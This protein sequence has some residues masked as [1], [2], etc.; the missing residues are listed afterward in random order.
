MEHQQQSATHHIAQR[1]VGLLP[2]PGF[3][4]LPRQLPAA[5]LRMISNQLPDEEDLFPGDVSAPVAMCDHLIRGVPESVSERQVKNRRLTLCAT[6]GPHRCPDC[7]PPA[8]PVP[9]APAAPASV[10]RL[11]AT[12]ESVPWKAAW[13]PT[14]SL[15]H[16]RPTP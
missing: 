9:D 1:A 14:K 5:Q 13:S 12:S 15:A 7:P 11:V 6:P 3:T 2:L 8:A 16:R 10:P 4:Q